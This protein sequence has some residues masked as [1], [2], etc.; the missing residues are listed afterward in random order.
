LLYD[1]PCG[2][3][4][5]GWVSLRADRQPSNETDGGRDPW[6]PPQLRDT[7]MNRQEQLEAVLRKM[8]VLAEHLHDCVPNTPSTDVVD[9][10]YREITTEVK[11]L[12]DEKQNETIG[13]E[14]TPGERR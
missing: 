10:E 12:L 9:D 14:Y 4:N 8:L 13:V 7:I 1:I 11:S 6:R 3:V 5:P 2:G